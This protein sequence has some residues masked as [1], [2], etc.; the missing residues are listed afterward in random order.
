MKTACANCTTMFTQPPIRR[1][2]CCSTRCYDEY[3]RREIICDHCGVSFKRK[4][5][6][7]NPPRFCS[8]RCAGLAPKP[9]V[10]RRARSCDF[11]GDD[12]I[13]E[14]TE[15]YCSV[16]CYRR[17]RRMSNRQTPPPDPV[18]GAKWVALT[19]GKFALVDEAD[20]ASI[21]EHGWSIGSGGYASARINQEQITLHRFLMGNDPEEIDHRNRNRLDNRR[22][23]LRRATRT[24]NHANRRVVGS[25]GFRGVNK[26]GRKWWA[27]LKN[28]VLGS[29]NSPEEAAIAYDAAARAAY[30][31]FAVLNYPCG[32]E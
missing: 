16:P 5:A 10:I 21:S 6:G 4:R 23:N 24:D 17:G 13:P 19:R 30:G 3:Q 15:R 31:E 32:G 1:R 29:F 7:L 27:K 22:C 18:P 9:A 11:C 8:V 14:T 12:F 28:K 25:S 20:F 2:L 26:S